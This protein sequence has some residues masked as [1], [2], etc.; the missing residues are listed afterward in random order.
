M[1][2][3]GKTLIHNIKMGGKCVSLALATTSTLTA[4]TT[5]AQLLFT[6]YTRNKYKE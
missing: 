4:I 5:V 6:I 1:H 2:T 3:T